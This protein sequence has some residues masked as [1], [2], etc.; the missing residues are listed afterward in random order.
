MKVLVCDDEPA[1]VRLIQVNLERRGYQI[2]TCY[3]GRQ[4]LDTVRAERPDLMVLDVMMPHVDGL[5]IL[6]AI[7]CDPATSEL[8]VIVLTAAAREADVYASMAHGAD[9][10]LTKPFHPGELLAFVKRMWP[11]RAAVLIESEKASV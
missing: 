7:R 1:I 3:D 11:V 2:V 4:I 9:L 5:A 6:S 8:P 10:C